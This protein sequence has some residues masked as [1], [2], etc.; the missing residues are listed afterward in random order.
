M[1]WRAQKHKV[2]HSNVTADWDTSTNSVIPAEAREAAKS[3]NSKSA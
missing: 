2:D 3:R 1:W